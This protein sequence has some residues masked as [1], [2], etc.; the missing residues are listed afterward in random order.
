MN[1][2]K[3]NKRKQRSTFVET[4]PTMDGPKSYEFEYLKTKE[5]IE[6]NFTSL[7]VLVGTLGRVAPLLLQEKGKGEEAEIAARIFGTLSE[8]PFEILWSLGEKVLRNVVIDGDTLIENLENDDG[9][10]AENIDEFYV[11]IIF[12]IK[13]NYPKVFSKVQEKLKDSGLLDKAK[14][15]KR[16]NDVTNKLNTP[17]T[18][19]S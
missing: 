10:F 7:K 16:I 9:Y 1:E 13:G 3:T 2:T 18:G 14:F 4:I 15:L 17:S 5:A 8:I 11:A 12:G 19:Q 6:V